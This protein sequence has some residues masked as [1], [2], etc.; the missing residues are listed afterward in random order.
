MIMQLSSHDHAYL[1]SLLREAR[2]PIPAGWH[3]WWLEG[4]SQPVGVMSPDRLQWLMQ[5]LPGDAPM[6]Q[7]GPRWVWMAKHLSPSRRGDVLQAVAQQLHRQGAVVGW[8]DE[9]YS[10]WSPQEADWPYQ[11]PELFRLERAAFRFFGLRSHASHVHGLTADGRMWCGRRALSKATDPGLL[12]NLAAGGLPADEEPHSCAVREILEEA[13][14]SRTLSEVVACPTVITT[15]RAEPEGW[16]SETLFVYTTSVS[17][18]E[19]PI[20]QDGEVSE[21][22]CLETSEVLSRMR[23][24]EFTR[25][26]ACAI[27]VYLLGQEAHVNQRPPVS[28]PAPAPSR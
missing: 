21:F 6:K 17:D 25:D 14:L 1:L 11:E 4:G 23:A 22:L 27:A 8:R 15:E 10:S 28:P 18:T 9:A 13:G 12:D 16:H 24:G 19:I 20:N 2:A 5:S 7:D 26:A 3:P